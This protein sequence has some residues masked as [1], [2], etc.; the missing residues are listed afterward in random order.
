MYSSQ[1]AKSQWWKDWQ[2]VDLELSFLVEKTEADYS[3]A[4]SVKM[5]FDQGQGSQNNRD[6]LS[7]SN[8]GISSNLAEIF[9]AACTIADVTKESIVNG[10][11]NAVANLENL[12]IV[13]LKA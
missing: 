2:D 8:N 9:D 1:E 11:S 3:R 12:T 10:K 6:D 13:K 5:V 7:L 4:S